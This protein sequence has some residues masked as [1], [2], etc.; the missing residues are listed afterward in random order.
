MQLA[1]ISPEC[2][3]I[4]RAVRW[5][6]IIEKH[7]GPDSWAAVLRWHD[8]EFLMV[9]GHPVLLPVD[10]A[11]HRN[12]TILRTIWSEDGHSLTLFLQDKTYDDHWS[13]SG[14]MAVCDRLPGQDFYLAI[15]YHEWFILEP[16]SAQVETL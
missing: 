4:I 2:L 14:F 8:P 16:L 13:A 15:L 3:E 11:R 7:E 9:E 5:D 6:R 1:D 10:Q 12:I